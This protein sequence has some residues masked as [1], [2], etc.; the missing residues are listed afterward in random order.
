MGR[1][2]ESDIF[3]LSLGEWWV[4]EL[5]VRAREGSAPLSPPDYGIDRSIDDRT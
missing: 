4:R 2:P 5:G 3:L 1:D